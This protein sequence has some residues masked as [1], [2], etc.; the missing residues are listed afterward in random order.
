M[1]FRNHVRRSRLFALIFT[2]AALCCGNAL[3]QRNGAVATVMGSFN[4]PWSF[5]FLPDGR[6]LVTEKP[7]TMKLL[8]ARNEIYSITGLP[9]VTYHPPGTG[10]GGL[11]DVVLHPAYAQNQL[12]YISYAEPGTGGTS[13]A[14]VAR[15]RLNLT[16]TGGSLTNVEVIWRQTPKVTGNG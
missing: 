13:G 5:T 4:E 9:Q 11:G 12:V 3:A 1:S 7:G 16:A 14:A 10:Q 6:V 8:A 15:A 2:V